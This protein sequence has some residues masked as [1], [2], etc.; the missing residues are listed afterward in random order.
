M[1]FSS[2][3]SLR[4]RTFVKF[5]EP[6]DRVVLFSP[7]L[8]KLAANG[9]A[10]LSFFFLLSFTHSSFLLSYLFL[11]LSFS[12][13]LSMCVCLPLAC[14]CSIALCRGGG[15][16]LYSFGPSDVR[17]SVDV[18]I[19]FQGDSRDSVNIQTQKKSPFKQ[20]NLMTFI[21]FQR[22]NYLNLVYF[23]K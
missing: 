23:C 1:T 17:I 13:Y 10:C 4:K 9:V 21:S 11:A 2:D 5:V 3:F 12:R 7:M 16:Y 19:D 14:N 20:Y 8:K 22:Q 15:F 6:D 18:Y